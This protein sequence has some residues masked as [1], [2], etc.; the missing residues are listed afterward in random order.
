[1]QITHTGNVIFLVK[2]SGVSAG[3][4]GARPYT[5]VTKS[6]PKPALFAVCQII[7]LLF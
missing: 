4:P 3:Y 1:L 2:K 5:K 7:A 6:K